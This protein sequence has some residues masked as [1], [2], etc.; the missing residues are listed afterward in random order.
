MFN[1]LLPKEYK[2][3]DAFEKHAAISVEAARDFVAMMENFADAPAKSKRIHDAEHAGDN[4]TH[5]TMDMLHRT[6][7]TPIDRDQIHALITKMDDVLDRLHGAS[8]HIMLYDIPAPTQTLKELANTLYKSTLELQK[9]VTFLRNT[10]DIQGLQNACIE[11]NKLE[12]DGDALRDAAV[13]KLFKE[14]KDA[15]KLIKWKEIYQ[16]V[17][18][19]LDCCEDAANIIEGLVLEAN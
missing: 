10:K 6:F 4:L 12:N 16:D 13:G 14:E 5:E 9:A 11:I 3:F 1:F 15:V 19:A 17:E 2:F 8:Q 7:I 18:S